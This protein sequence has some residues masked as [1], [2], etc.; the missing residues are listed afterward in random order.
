MGSTF[1]SEQYDPGVHGQSSRAL[2]D[3]YLS[4]GVFEDLSQQTVAITGTSEGG[5]GFSIAEVAIRQKVKH[6]LVLNRESSS[7]KK[8][9]EGLKA[10][11][12]ETKSPTNLQAVACDLQDLSSVEKA[13]AE[14]N[15]IAAKDKGLDIL[16]CNA[17][18]MAL[19]DVRTKDGF[20]VQMQTNQLSHFLLIA[21]VWPS[22]KAAAQS[23]GAARVVTHSSSARTTPSRDLEKEYFTKC[24][25]GTLGGDYYSMFFQMMGWK[26]NWQR[27]HQTKLANANFSMALHDKIQAS[28]DSTVKKILSNSADPGIATSNLQATTV[29]D[30]SMPSWLAKMLSGTAQSPADGS[31]PICMAAFGKG[32][33]SGSFFMPKGQTTG[34][35]IATIEEGMPVKKG[36]EPAVVSEK[37]K[38]NVWTFC[39]EALGI[40]FSLD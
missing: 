20:E 33:K 18:V 17:G 4:K 16:I 32:V 40:K 30:G 7:S 26:G 11:I 24:E 38:T 39:E 1:S 5:I 14:V 21:K 12:D 29:K 31:L 3:E 25:A 10:L 37:N 2:Y 35:P 34:E 8:G 36:G 27:Y 6:L 15:K 28:T 9:F 13:A 19:K 22:V 23:R